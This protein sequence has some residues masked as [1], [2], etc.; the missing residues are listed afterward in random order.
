MAMA[1]RA[2]LIGPGE[3]TTYPASGAHTTFKVRA[4]ETQGMFE[5]TETSLPI[6]FGGPPPHVHGRIDHAFYVL[7]GEIQYQTGERMVRASAGSSV[8]VPHGVAHKF[9]NPAANPARML[10]IDSHGGRE[11]MFKE[12]AAAF[13]PGSLLEPKLMLEILQKYDTRPA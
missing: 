6:R 10:Q 11:G 13:P 7:E 5:L 3:G 2:G 8:F 4:E 12:M 9:A 1:E